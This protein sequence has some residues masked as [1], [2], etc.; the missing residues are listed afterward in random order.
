MG[1]KRAI[2]PLVRGLVRTLSPSGRVADL[3]SGMGSVACSLAPDFPVLTNDLLTFTAAF[4]RAR[5][6]NQPRLPT[7]RV[8]R[9]LLPYFRS[10]YQAL[11]EA[12][13][14]RLPGER[15]AVDHP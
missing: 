6:L 2:A 15:R 8:A 4:A 12:F 9:T 10:S 3:F 5:F 1:T 13:A 7:E 14:D 11:S